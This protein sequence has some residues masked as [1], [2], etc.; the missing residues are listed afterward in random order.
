MLD[1]QA[2]TT[3]Q[4]SHNYQRMHDKQDDVNYQR[5]RNHQRQHGERND[6]NYRR[7]YNHDQDYYYR[8]DDNN[9]IENDI[10]ENDTT[11][12]IDEIKFDLDSCIFTSVITPVTELSPCYSGCLGSVEFIMRRKNKTITLQWEPFTCKLTT[13]GISFLTVCQSMCNLPPY[14]IIKPIYIEYKGNIRLTFVSVEPSNSAH[15]KFYLNTDGS[16]IGTS[17]DDN[18][19]IYGGCI[20]WLLR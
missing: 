12:N 7:N 19:L 8:S 1:T 14:K 5:I 13:N 10:T 15:I 20:E 3:Y 6:D 9:T 17:V 11:K 16:S 18:I 4:R 2:D